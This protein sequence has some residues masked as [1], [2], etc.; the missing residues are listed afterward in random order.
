MRTKKSG[1]TL[2]ELLIVVAILA[3][4]AA[5]AVPNFLEAQTRAK[6][7]REMN[8]LRTMSTAMEA[9]MIDHNSYTRDSDSSLELQYTGAAA[10]IASIGP[11]DCFNPKS[12]NF[13]LCANGA[14][15]LTTPVAYMQTLLTD[16][17][18]DPGAIKNG[19]SAIGYRIASGAWSYGSPTFNTK[20]DQSSAEV[21][22]KTGPVQAYALIGIGPDQARCRMG[23]KNF[24]FMDDGSLATSEFDQNTP[25]GPGTAMAKS[26]LKGQTTE[27]AN[28]TDYDA[29]N[30]TSS[31]GD[32]YRFGG[33]IGQGHWMHNGQ[34]V[35]STG[36]FGAPVW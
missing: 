26:T 13:G 27:P 15:T 11:G 18:A 12:P 32:V 2:I 35:G 24:P 31:V 36:G 28:W 19:S 29:S 20:D 21:F 10:G 17:F 8:D 33:S 3:I 14:L 22:A 6:V 7:A 4:L 23:Y 25:A 1:F 9:Y 34:E 5:I 30:G 16:P